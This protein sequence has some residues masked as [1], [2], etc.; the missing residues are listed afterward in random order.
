[1]NEVL[2][3]EGDS[4]G[5]KRTLVVALG[6]KRGYGL[7]LLAY[8][9]A[10]AWIILGLAARFYG[11]WA[12]LA[13]IPAAVF[14]RDLLPGRVLKDRADTIRASRDT[15]LSQMLTTAL[16]ACSFLF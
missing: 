13:L 5:G 6:E 15:I 4:R 3:I 14:F 8:A 16:L 1:V 9:G 10:Y 7:F 11:A 12:A 2:D